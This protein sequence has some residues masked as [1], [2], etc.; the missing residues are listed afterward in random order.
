MDKGVDMEQ[1]IFELA[2]YGDIKDILSLI[3]LRIKWMDE[4]GIEQWNK[5]NYLNCYPS[6]YFENCISRKELY[7][8]KVKEN[9]TIVGA[10]AL[11]TYDS[12]WKDKD[13]SYYIH[14][15]VT[16]VNACCAGTVLINNCELVAKNNNKRYLRLDCQASNIKL[17]RYYERLGFGYVGI[18]KDGLY[19]GNKRE[20]II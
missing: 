11:H 10:V 2:Q 18:I 1:Y 15:L 17:N 19:I 8:L 4:K 3:K 16:S 7:V 6:E 12:R 20:K 13:S 14:N 9:K 5:T